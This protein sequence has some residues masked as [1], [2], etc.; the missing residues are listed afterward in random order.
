M[1][2]Q[3]EGE[4]FHVVE[5]NAHLELE[6]SLEQSI[7]SLSSNR[8]F[9]PPQAVHS[10]SAHLQSLENTVILELPFTDCSLNF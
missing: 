3:A 4:E 9:P 10:K 6:S 1:S 8:E 7:S 2:H 5:S